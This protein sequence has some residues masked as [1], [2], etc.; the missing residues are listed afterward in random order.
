VR[1]LLAAATRPAKVVYVSRDAEPAP[2]LDEIAAL[3]GPILRVVPIEK[4]AALARTDTHQGVVATAR[5][6]L[7]VSVD[8]LLAVD[9]CFVLALEGVTDPHNLGAVLRSAAAFGVTG[10]VVPNRRATLVTPAVAKAAAGAIEHVPIALTSGIPAALERARRAQV[11][12]V[13]L[14]ADG[15]TEIDA[16]TVADESIVLVM[17]AEGHGLSRLSTQ[18]CDVVARIPIADHVESLNVSVAAAIALHEIARRRRS[19]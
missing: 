11:W 4:L 6:L 10:V 19:R 16:I 14:A 12:T 1:E 18:R 13:G 15:G 3:A 17:G 5:P 9:G 7:P 2:V 8:D